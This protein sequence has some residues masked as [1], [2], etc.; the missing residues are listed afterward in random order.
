[1]GNFL[2]FVVF[3]WAIFFLPMVTAVAADDPLLTVHQQ[4][5]DSYPGVKHIGLQDLEKMLQTD[6]DGIIFFDVREREEY[7]VSHIKDAI[8]IPPKMSQDDFLT[9]YGDRVNN[10]T[11]VFYC[12][13]GHRSSSFSQGIQDVLQIKGARQS[14]NMKGGLFAWHNAS[15]PVE[16]AQGAT[17]AIHPYNR[18]WGKLINRKSFIRYSPP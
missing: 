12:S 15:W 13:V 6:P 3:L 9:L 1:M 14:Y 16:N 7:V 2:Q 8:Y 4:V 17:Q 18:H 10:K 5:I 11:V